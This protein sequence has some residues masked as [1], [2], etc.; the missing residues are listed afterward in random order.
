MKKWN[1]MAI[2][3]AAVI[4]ISVILTILVVVNL[5]HKQASG[6]ANNASEIPQDV[7]LYFENA[8]IISCEEDAISVL[9][10]GET[11]SFSGV[12]NEPYIG[13]AD[14]HVL[15]DVVDSVVAK[16]NYI[17]GT[18]LGYRDGEVKIEGYDWAEKSPNF[19]IYKDYDG[20][21]ES[22]DA[23]RLVYGA[24]KLEYCV[25][26]NVVC[27]AVQRTRTTTDEI[28]VVI[29]NDEGNTVL[30]PEL[31]LY[32]K[33]RWYANGEEL[34]AEK[35]LDVVAYMRERNL[36]ELEVTSEGMIA[37]TDENGKRKGNYFEG[38]F[39]VTPYDYTE[40][41][42]GGVVLVNI[43]PIEDYLRYVLPSEM[44]ASFDFEALKAQA[45]CARTYAYSQMQNGQYAAYGANLDDSTMYQVYN[46][47][48][49]RELTDLAVEETRGQVVACNGDLITCY[50]FSTTPGT[51]DDMEVWDSE[52]VP[53]LTKHNF[54][55][56]RTDLSDRDNLEEFLKAED[57]AC[58]DD[59]SPFYR[60][61]AT[62][63]FDSEKL[64]EA[65]DP[66]YGKLKSFQITKRTTSGYVC[67]L[68]AT[69]ENETVQMTK[70]LEIRRFLGKYLTGVTLMDGSE[71]TN[72]TLIPCAFFIIDGY[73]DN[74]VVKDLDKKNPTI[75]LCGGGFGHGLGMSQYGANAMAKAGMD[76]QSIIK[77]YYS[78]VEIV[79]EKSLD[80]WN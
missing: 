79:D 75:T 65:Q 21:I 74:I 36:E 68:T 56:L 78:N 57:L 11:Y 63:S 37:R 54:T 2:L 46:E 5:L 44:P 71:R 40:G 59:I 32:S 55:D 49:T 69:Y 80:V 4:L 48:G 47:A 41:L 28:R 52:N 61:N 64:K 67:G 12:L 8:Y 30:Y 39:V 3:I 70:E 13:I 14:V 53:Y 38:R 60:W 7:E 51:T 17:S 18:I 9:Y 73:G 31:Y 42:D 76:Y 24:T 6:K 20:V 45:V 58:Y 19:K 22:V 16:E 15:N 23:N 72:F 77:A 62:L 35:T 27:A 34:P 26:D 1:K 29:K 10:D 66:E 43:L 33:E 50:Y 25:A